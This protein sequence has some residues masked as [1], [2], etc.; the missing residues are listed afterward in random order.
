NKGTTFRV[1]LPLTLATFRGI[2]VRVSGRLFVIPIINV[3]RILRIKQKDIKTVENKQVIPYNDSTV[4]FNRLDDVLGIRKRLEKKEKS[5]FLQALILEAGENHIAFGVDEI[6]YEQEVLVKNIGKPITRVRNIAGAT[7]LGSGMVIPILNVA[8]LIR[9]AVQGVAVEALP[10]EVERMKEVKPK[11]VVVA[12]D[13]ITS[14]MLLK[15][16]LE[17]AGFLV[18]TA[19]DGADAFSKLREGDF[20]ILVS[21]IDM[22]RMNGFELTSKIRSDKKLGD[23][24]VV[25]VT[26]LKSREDRERGMDAGA[27][28]YIE[29][30]SF[31]PQNLLGI[32]SRLL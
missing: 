26:A 15:D 2:F 27:N 9:S 13:S 19:V 11:S 4:S 32:V 12:E 23:L 24:P 14:R 6:L 25:L 20:D 7:V 30:G 17:S 29:K 21:D 3:R 18:K 1:N 31:D 22:P 8:D 16:I 5:G 10:V 28:A